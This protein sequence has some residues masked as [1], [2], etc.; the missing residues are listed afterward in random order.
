M[1]RFTDL[2][3]Q[4]TLDRLVKECGG[5][6]V[7]IPTRAPRLDESVKQEI[8]ASTQSAHVTAERYRISARTV[9]RLKRRAFDGV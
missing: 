2:I 7:Y 3:P 6:Y 5:T 4:N 8:A 1:S 9:F